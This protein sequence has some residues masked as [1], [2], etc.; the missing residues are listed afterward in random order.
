MNAIID[1]QKNH[2]L[3]ADG[4][5]GKKTL[6]KI[7]EVIGSH[8]NEEL[9]HFMGQCAHESGN[10]TSVVE[11]LNYSDVGLLKNF[12]KYFNSSNVAKY[13]RQPEKIANRVYAN[14]MGNGDE[15]SG[16]G[17]K[18]RGMGLIQL[19]GKWNHEKFANSINSSEIKENPSLIATKYAFESAKFYFD[20]RDLWEY[21][22]TIDEKSIL[23]ISRAINLGSPNSKGTPKG[24]DDRIEK[25]KYYYNLIKS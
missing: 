23:K 1:F 21:A 7:N 9:A 14:R 2:G 24:L 6:A 18:Y 5:I 19:T 22:Q 12:S 25:T 17:W 3:I 13:E 11:N 4:I 10:F 8:S 15:N 20:S 16:D